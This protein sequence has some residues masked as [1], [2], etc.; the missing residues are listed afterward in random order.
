MAKGTKR[1][2][3]RRPVKPVPQGTGPGDDKAPDYSKKKPTIKKK[4]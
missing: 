4:K 2:R 3:I 1:P